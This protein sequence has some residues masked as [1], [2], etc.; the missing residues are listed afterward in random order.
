M[1]GMATFLTAFQSTPK[2]RYCQARCSCCLPNGSIKHVPLLAARPSPGTFPTATSRFCCESPDT[3]YTVFFGSEHNLRSANV[4]VC[5]G[6]NPDVPNISRLRYFPAGS[7]TTSVPLKSMMMTR[8]VLAVAYACSNAGRSRRSSPN[9]ASRA[10][11]E[12][13]EL[14]PTA[15]ILVVLSRVASFKS[16]RTFRVHSPEGHVETKSISRSRRAPLSLNDM[17]NDWS[18]EV[19]HIWIS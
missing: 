1:M 17:D 5:E 10:R 3:T 6:L 19:T 14:S 15:S 18:M 12:S 13:G 16:R 7:F 8:D 2:S 11:I 9:S 4:V